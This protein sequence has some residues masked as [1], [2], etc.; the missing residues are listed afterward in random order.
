MRI[1][2]WSSYV[3]SSDLRS[4]AALDMRLEARELVRPQRL[5]LGA[6]LLEFRRRAVLQSIDSP[7]RVE[8]RMPF[9]EQPPLLQ[10]AQMPTHRGRSEERRAAKECVYTCRYR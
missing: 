10:P 4:R 2:D 1:S 9:L 6:P 5:G 3:C 8:R 7:A